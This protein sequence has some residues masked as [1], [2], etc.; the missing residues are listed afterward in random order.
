MF[1]PVCRSFIIAYGRKCSRCGHVLK[2]KSKFLNKNSNKKNKNNK[3]KNSSSKKKTDNHKKTNSK[4]L[5]SRL[6]IID[7][8]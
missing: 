8:A 5:L 1:C 4:R 7:C 6:S 2:E 3:S